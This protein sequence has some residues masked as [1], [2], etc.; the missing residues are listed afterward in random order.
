MQLAS[1]A[2]A[3]S[4]VRSASGQPMAAPIISKEFPIRLGRVT[5]VAEGQTADTVIREIHE[6]GL[7]TCQIG[8]DNLSVEVV[9]PLQAALRKYAV[10]V[11]AISEHNPGPRIFDFYH[12]PETVGIIPPATRPARVKA[13]KVAA[14]VA[15]LA[16]IPAIHAH[17]GFIPEN[18]ND[19]IYPQ[20]VAAVKDVAS[21]CKE[22]GLILL[23]ET[24]QETPITLVRLIEDVNLGNVFVNLDLANLIL[25]GKGNPVDAM[26]VFGSR[27]RGI[28]AKDGQFP[29]NTRELGVEAPIGQGKVDF[30]EVFTQLRKLNYSGTMMIEREVGNE[31][32]RKRDILQSKSFLETLIARTYS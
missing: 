2:Y 30:P 19:P 22:R 4:T 18:P 27:V 16:G 23:C 17:C 21:Y 28:H 14:D 7:Q 20:A 15:N 1:V 26:E 10:E 11:N 25:Y 31:E 29:T 12:G 13:M 8:F 3:A 5:W 6:L 9:A 24:G 32:E